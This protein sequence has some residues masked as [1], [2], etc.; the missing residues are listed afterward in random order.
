[1]DDERTHRLKLAGWGVLVL[2]WLAVVV[3]DS[4]GDLAV[5]PLGVGVGLGLV[6][7]VVAA[8]AVVGTA[9]QTRLLVGAFLV[10][11][12]T[13]LLVGTADPGW[14]PFTTER[15][16]LTADLTIFGAMVLLLWRRF[17]A[18]PGASA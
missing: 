17:E 11:G 6:V 3:T 8:V 14:L 12:G 2:A 15:T 1:M 9:T 13:A 10:V 4:T 18:G 7:A 16:S 5:A